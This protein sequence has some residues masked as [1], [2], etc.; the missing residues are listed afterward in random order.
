MT[1]DT[2]LLLQRILDA[3]QMSVGDPDFE[4]MAPLVLSAKDELRQAIEAVMT[5]PVVDEVPLADKKA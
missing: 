4:V 2:L 5:T 3:Q 1:L